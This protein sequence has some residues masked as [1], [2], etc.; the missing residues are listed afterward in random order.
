MRQSWEDQMKQL[1]EEYDHMPDETNP[2][3]IWDHVQ[4]A[5]RTRKRRAPWMGAIAGVVAAASIAGLL[6]MS[7]T[8]L[9]PDDRGAG[10]VASDDREPEEKTDVPDPESEQEEDVTEQ[11]HGE[12]ENEPA[13]S[14]REPKKEITYLIEGTNDTGTFQLLEEPGFSFTTYIPEFFETNVTEEGKLVVY[15][16]FSADQEPTEEPVWTITEH[17]DSST[18][19]TKAEE[20]LTRYAQ[21]GWELA[22][23]QSNDLEYGDY[24]A[25]FEGETGERST[26]ILLQHDDTI[27]EWEQ[28]YPVEMGDGLSAREQV[29]MDEWEWK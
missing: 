10:E 22:N 18:L 26:V 4:S 5:R 9:P 28:S 12:P 2:E 1:K 20:I 19:E 25:T 24:A 21:Q 11:P 8:S 16:A 23:Q 6:V 3:Q 14:N 17:T 27:V 13:N 29:V 7:Q 15:A